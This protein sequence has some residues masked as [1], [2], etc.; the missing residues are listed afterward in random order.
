VT[1]L[2]ALARRSLENPQVSLSDASL[3]EWL[4]GGRTR[5]GSLV[6]EQRVL[7]LPSYYRAMA[8]RS[9]VEAALP[10]KVYRRGTRERVQIKTVLDA[11]NPS[12]TPF[13]FWQTMRMNGIGWGDS[14]ARK[15]RNGADVVTQMWPMHPSRVRVEP[16]DITA[17]NPEGKL[18]LVTD[19]HGVEHRLT[20]WE[21]FHVPFMSPDGLTGV[22]AFRAFRESLGIGIAA[23]DAAGALFANGNRLA[24]VL[25]TKMKLEEP[26]AN[27]LKARWRERYGGAEQAGQV[28]VLDNGAEFKPIAIPPQDAQ[29]LSSRQWTVAEIA[30][31]VGVLPHMIGDTERSTS[32]GTGIEQQFIGWVVTTVGPELT[33]IDQMITADLLPGGW[34][35]GSYYAEHD[36]NGLL[37]GDSAARSAFYHQL[38]TDGVLTKNEVRVLENREPVENGDDFLLPAGVLPAGIAEMTAKV[39]ALA[40]LVAK[41]FDPAAAAAALGLPPIAHTGLM[42][43]TVTVQE[44]L[45]PAAPAA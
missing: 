39:N 28:A 26:A 11:P 17:K 15:V 6:S 45:Q 16:V 4:G 38:L 18:F 9:G 8:I 34:G 42:P 10:L 30:R 43:T 27:R 37:K 44:S 13:L 2:G 33:N 36:L 22:S 14:F 40:A 12:Q 32:W 1:L 5:A 23:E 20:Q 7:G 25:Q 24:G 31:M 21:V 35:S 3:A 41:G 29:L 19:R